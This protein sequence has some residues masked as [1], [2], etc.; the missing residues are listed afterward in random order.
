MPLNMDRDFLLQNLDRDLK[1]LV[2]WT[3]VPSWEMAVFITHVDNL[4]GLRRDWDNMLTDIMDFVAANGLKNV[5]KVHQFTTLTTEEAMRFQTED[6]DKATCD[7]CGYTFGTEQSEENMTEPAVKTRCGHVLGSACL[8]NW[9]D[10]G[11]ATCPSCRQAMYGMELALP[12]AVMH[13]YNAV[14]HA[15][16]LS[17]RMDKALD[18]YLLQGNKEVHDAN[19][20]EFVHRLSAVGYR[21]HS[22]F[23]TLYE[24]IQI[25]AS[26]LDVGGESSTDK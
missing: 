26:M 11:H 5:P 23:A 9:V 17:K 19:F 14:I 10:S 25:E 15:L 18:T 2:D 4:M 7:I 22:Q 16:K 13:H 1:W 24:R 8:Q 3:V 12:P 20:T 21:L 6:G